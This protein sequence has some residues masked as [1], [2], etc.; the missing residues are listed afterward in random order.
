MQLLTD[1]LRNCLVSCISTF[2]AMWHY[3]QTQMEDMQ[4]RSQ[5]PRSRKEDK[6][7]VLLADIDMPG[8]K[9]TGVGY[10]AAVA[11]SLAASRSQ[12]SSPKAKHR[13]FTS[14]N[15]HATYSKAHHLDPTPFTRE[16]GLLPSCKR[17]R[18]VCEMAAAA[19]LAHQ[20][21]PSPSLH[22]SDSGPGE[23]QHGAAR[24][25]QDMSAAPRADHLV[26]GKAAAHAARQDANL[27]HG[28][29]PLQDR[30]DQSSSDQLLLLSKQDAGAIQL[31]QQAPNGQKKTP[32]GYL[33]KA[34]DRSGLVHRSFRRKGTPHRS[35]AF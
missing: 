23:A 16:L 20:E 11:A 22:K 24:R 5:R 19:A 28:Q 32:R 2:E 29:G 18:T 12:S 17:R 33:Q 26:A 14:L 4:R 34:A 15:S 21:T 35:S 1:A 27:H 10:E 30:S 7:F 31:K 9:S 3:L 6:D 25:L 13:T 8:R